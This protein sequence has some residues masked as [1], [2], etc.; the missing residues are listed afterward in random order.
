VGVCVCMSLQIDSVLHTATHCNS[1]QLSA[2]HCNTLQHTATHCNT[3]QHTATHCTVQA[4]IL[5]TLSC[6]M[7]LLG[8]RDLAWLYLQTMAYWWYCIDIVYLCIHL[9]VFPVSAIDKAQEH[10]KGEKFLG[11]FGGNAKVATRCLSVCVYVCEYICVCMQKYVCLCVCVD[12]CLC[13]VCLCV[14]VCRCVCM[15]VR[16]CLCTSTCVCTCLRV[17]VVNIAM[18]FNVLW[19]QG[20]W[21][22][23]MAV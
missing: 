8:S 22:A 6:R 17:G 21:R 23:V 2:T 18:G 12:V 10:L 13:C 15:C 20:V 9:Y 1:L 14:L 11:F 19:W 5:N 3:Q 16:A 7:K 4:Q